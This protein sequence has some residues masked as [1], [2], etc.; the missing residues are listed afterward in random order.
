MSL[1]IAVVAASPFPTLQGSQVLVRQ[2][3]QAMAER[4]HTVH[5]V[6]YHLGLKS[7]HSEGERQPGGEGRIHIHR[8]ASIPFYN[9]MRAGPSIGKPFLDVLLTLK[10]FRVAR[11]EKID[12]FHAHHI[13]GVAAAWPVARWQ[14]K[15]IVFHSHT[16]MEGELP[17]YFENPAVRRVARRA[18]R[19][20]DT[21]LPRLADCTIVLSREARATFAQL[22]NAW[23]QLVLLPPGIDDRPVAVVTKPETLK[24]KYHLGDG[25]LAIS[26]G[27]LD[28][29]QGLNDLL[30]AFARVRCA[31]PD[32]ELIIASHA[33][34]SDIDRRA[35]DLSGDGVRFIHVHSFDEA[36]ELLAVSHVAVCPRPACLGYPIKLLNYMSAAKAIVC[37][38]GSA[39]NIIH[40]DNGYIYA[41]GDVG[42]LATGLT[43]L[44]SD[45][46]LAGRLGRNAG[47][48]AQHFQWKTLAESFE[49][50]YYSL[51]Q[52]GEAG[53]ARR[54]HY[55]QQPV[56]D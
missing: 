6:T 37:A 54:A 26:T 32:A 36:A 19:W 25:P 22:G 3:A 18:G 46:A 55:A 43:R 16:L 1:R 13:E 56:G 7:P 21:Y 39:R 42:A 31:V 48:T 4:G 15:P 41:D 23:D 11:R 35:I 20:L 8:I 45:R 5:I 30:R 24:A 29:Y 28:A 10:L 2:H 47:V 14:R 33:T 40:L 9:R 44:L 34:Q 53:P 27:N 38:A 17:E 12:V 50:L 49:S 51:M 52:P